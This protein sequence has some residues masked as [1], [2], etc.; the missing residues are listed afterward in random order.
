MI[1][2]I[3]IISIVILCIGCKAHFDKEEWLKHPD[4]T[5]SK[6]P[7]FDMIDDLRKNIIVEGKSNVVE[8]ESLLGN[9]WRVDTI[10]SGIEYQYSIGSN[11]GVHIDPYSLVI[12]FNRDN[13]V[14]NTRLIKH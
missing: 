1:R 3:T 9:P 4:R 5:D 11:P 14:V 12:E 13:I 2:L 7:R 10:K 8:I 6:N